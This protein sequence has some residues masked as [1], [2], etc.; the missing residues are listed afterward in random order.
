M[1]APPPCGVPAFPPL[2]VRVGA[3]QR[4]RRAMW[5]QRR[6][7]AAGL[8]LTAAALAVSGLAGDGDGG[9]GGD[10]AR[11][12]SRER[13]SP[14][15]RLVSAPVRIA[16]AET[17]RLL[18]PGDR[19]DVVASGGPGAAAEEAR[20]V[21]RGAR[22]ERVPSAEAGGLSGE[23]ALIVLA[24]PRATAAGLAGAGISG[25]FAVVLC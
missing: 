15:V 25:G 20:V 3:G 5:R 14:P 17:V 8:A 21:A 24:V 23:G 22:V 12:A 16:D 7:M 1:P 11:A 2:R 18:R 6:S 10:T 9:H 19:V 13:A 4:L